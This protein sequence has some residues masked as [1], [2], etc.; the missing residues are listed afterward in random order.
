MS[1]RRA[2]SIPGSR[3]TRK[4]ARWSAS[5]SPVSGAG[6][7][8]AES[9]TIW[10]RSSASSTESARPAMPLEEVNTISWIRDLYQ[11]S[12]CTGSRGPWHIPGLMLNYIAIEFEAPSGFLAMREDMSRP[13]LTIVATRG[14]P[15]CIAVSGARQAP[16]LLTQ[17]MV[18]ARP[19]ANLPLPGAS[20][21]MCTGE[22]QGCVLCWPLIMDGAVIGALGLQ[23]PSGQPPFASPDLERG[24]SLG[25]FLSIAIENARL[26][27]EQRQRI[28]E[29]SSANAEIQSINRKL[30]QAQH[31]LLQAEK[32]ASIG[33]LAA[34]VA[35]EINNP[36]GYV[37]SNLGSLGTYIVDL[38]RVVDGYA[39][40]ER[41]HDVAAALFEEVRRMRKEAD[42]DFLREDIDALMVETR[43]GVAR[44]HKIVQ[45][46]RDFSRAG[47]EDE[48]QWAD[49]HR[50]LDSTLNIVNNEIK[51]KAQVVKEYGSLPE[52]ECLPSQLNQGFL[53]L[54]V[55]AAQAIA[56]KGVITVRTGVGEDNVW[57][58]IADTGHG[59]PAQHL[60]RV[61]EPFFTTKPVG[62]GTGLGLSLSYS[63]VRKHGGNIEV[64]SEPGRGTSFRVTLPISPVRRTDAPQ[65]VAAA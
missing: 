54:L 45:D 28:E 50:G 38:L 36:I 9:Q 15:S 31:Q 49:L 63:I 51:Y 10:K 8:L 3:R 27:A 7:S 14:D 65:P 62:Q 11:I 25:A 64:T 35:H 20:Q 55:N 30:N 44:V 46:L 1:S 41:R 61:F 17:I 18:E 47:S 34:G 4:I 60:Q 13:T 26:H 16:S 22:E 59:I 39:E 52:I 56:G 58:D 32:M 29:L 33:Q 53:N 12:Q 6:S 19:L 48:W 57:V 40:V 42:L 37:N 21:L 2:P 5:V 43:E 24:S 23:R